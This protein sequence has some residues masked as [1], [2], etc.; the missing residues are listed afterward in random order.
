MPNGDRLEIQ[1]DQVTIEFSR[2]FMDVTRWTGVQKTYMADRG[3][4]TIKGKL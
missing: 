3:T 2:D 4:F 1:S